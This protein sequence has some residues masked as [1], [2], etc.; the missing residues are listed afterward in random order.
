MQIHVLLVY[1]E[2]VRARD[3]RVLFFAHALIGYFFAS[4]GF[5]LVT[6]LS[7]FDAKGIILERQ[8]VEQKRL[9]E[10]SLLLTLVR[11]ENC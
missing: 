8:H 9:D 2:E 11:G 4:C 10:L 5:S 7:I 6:F 3:D 1:R